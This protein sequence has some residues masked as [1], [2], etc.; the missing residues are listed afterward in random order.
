[1]WYMYLL[2]QLII[3]SDGRMTRARCHSFL[4]LNLRI[5][6]VLTNHSND[7]HKLLSA[8]RPGDRSSDPW[9]V[10]STVIVVFTQVRQNAA[11]RGSNQSTKA[12]PI[13]KYKSGID[14]SLVHYNSHWFIRL[15]AASNSLQFQFHTTGAHNGSYD[16]RCRRIYKKERRCSRTL[17]TL[18]CEDAMCNR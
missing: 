16:T 13:W 3:M 11:N 12:V 7:H 5:N 17:L 15:I 2:C 14:D 6:H 8:R 1:M 18:H 9:T 10:V 4:F